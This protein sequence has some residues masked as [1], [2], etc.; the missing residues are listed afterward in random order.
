MH[1]QSMDLQ[2]ISATYLNSKSLAVLDYM[3][4]S[5]LLGKQSTKKIKKTGQIKHVLFGVAQSR[6]LPGAQD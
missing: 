6:S 1:S 3:N 2:S 5:P 4:A